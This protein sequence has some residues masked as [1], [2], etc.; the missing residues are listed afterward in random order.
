MAE[1]MSPFQQSHSM[2]AGEPFR[3]ERSQPEKNKQRLAPMSIPLPIAVARNGQIS[4]DVF[5]PVNQN[6]SFEFDKVL[7]SGHV[8]KRSRRT[9][10]SS[11]ALDLLE[12]SGL[13]RR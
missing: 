3:E 2:L 11:M 13:S 9:K 6:G 12:R 1:V 4:L 8:Y 5:S 7:K 10:V